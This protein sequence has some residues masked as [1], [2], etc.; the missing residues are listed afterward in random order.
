MLSMCLPVYLT[1]KNSQFCETFHP[2]F[3]KHCCYSKEVNVYIIMHQ[4]MMFMFTIER[5]KIVS[6][7]LQKEN[8]FQYLQPRI[9]YNVKFLVVFCE[10]KKT[11]VSESLC[12]RQANDFPKTFRL[13]ICKN[14]DQITK[15][16]ITTDNTLLAS[17]QIH[18]FI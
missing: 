3:Y 1:Y 4:Q 18:L 8:T 5:N 2:K 14:N 17:T 7:Q 10:C 9:I 15:T 12:G 13:F 11:C 6:Y 16:L